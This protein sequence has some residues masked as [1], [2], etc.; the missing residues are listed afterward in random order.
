M[1]EGPTVFLE[2]NLD[3]VGFCSRGFGP[4]LSRLLFGPCSDIAPV[5]TSVRQLHSCQ[6]KAKL[7]RAG[8][9]QNQTVSDWTEREIFTV[10]KV[11][12]LWAQWT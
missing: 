1:S 5:V 3:F 12:F 11:V 6:A 4:G 9:Y 8:L 7:C 10:N 2:I